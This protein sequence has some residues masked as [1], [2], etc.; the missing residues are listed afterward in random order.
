MDNKPVI[1][2]IV[3]TYYQTNNKK[4]DKEKVK[5]YFYKIKNGVSPA[6]IVQEMI[7][8]QKVST[9]G[10]CTG[11][12][13][14]GNTC[15]MNSVIQNIISCGDFI[16]HPDLEEFLSSYKSEKSQPGLL[17]YRVAQKFENFNN[18]HQHDSHE[19]FISLLD[20][21]PDKDTESFRGTFKVDV[22]FDDCGHINT[23]DEPFISLSLPVAESLQQAWDQFHQPETV[24]SSCDTCKDNKI[25]SGTKQFSI[26]NFPHYL[27]IHWKRFNNQHRKIDQP[28]AVPLQFDSYK[29]SGIVTHSGNGFG[30]HYTSCVRRDG[31][32]YFCNDA[33]VMEIREDNIVN[34]AKNSYMVFYEKTEMVV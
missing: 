6:E 17:H 34:S 18:R 1:S 22:K 19:W 30:G 33:S 8:D 13:N 24:Q 26:R 11:L 10:N 14:L 9:V 15:Y 31:H 5:N 2:W 4:P 3:R 12:Q 23:H 7:A 27:V 29:I 28:I 20:T 21:F 25:K 16:S 32:W